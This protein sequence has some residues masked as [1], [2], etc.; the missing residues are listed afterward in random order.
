MALGKRNR[1]SHGAHA[2]NAEKQDK[3]TQVGGFIP[4]SSGSV[5]SSVNSSH[6]NSHSA[7]AASSELVSCSRNN[8]KYTNRHDRKHHRARR[9]I[10]IVLIILLCLVVCAVAAYAWYMNDLNS[11]MTIQDPEQQQELQQALEPVQ[12]D[13]PFYVML[14]GSDSRGDDQGRS[15]TNIVVRVDPNSKQLTFI[16]IPRDTAI[17]IPGYGV[18][19]FNAAYQ[20][21][22]AAGAVKA[23]DEL[24]GIHISHYASIDFDATVELVDSLG[25][26]DV[27]VPMAIND[28]NAGGQVPQGMQHLNGEQ[29]L[30]FARS[31]SFA[32]GD[33]QRT[34]DQRLLMEALVTKLQST[35]AP[36]LAQAVDNVAKYVQTDMSASDILSYARDFQDSDVTTYSAMLPSSMVDVDGVSYVQCDVPTLKQMMQVVDDGGD[37]STVVPDVGV[38]S[39]EQAIREGDESTPVL[40]PTD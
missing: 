29:A 19:K 26:V 7:S 39:S 31:R 4:A 13:Q 9:I 30:I 33:F 28:A 23:A 11:K 6:Q 5:S 8:A 20:F 27:D 12:N 25:G 2:S 3:Q 35:S 37:P 32:N 40:T 18:Q 34:E 21:D 16:S 14:I 36:Q 38:S 1:T 15:D 24:L 17:E 10:L 22:G